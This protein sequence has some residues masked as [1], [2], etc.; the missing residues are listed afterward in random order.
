VKT[1]ATSSSAVAAA[2]TNWRS[3]S[4]QNLRSQSE[5]FGNYQRGGR[6]S[7]HNSRHQQNSNSEAFQRRPNS[8]NYYGSRQ[9]NTAPSAPF[10][11]LLL[12][13]QNEEANKVIFSYYFCVK[14]I[15][16]YLFGSKIVAMIYL[17]E[18]ITSSKILTD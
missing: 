18:N 11:E 10:S 5:F 7:Y 9:S 14:F 8:N 13:V 2:G 17:E 4:G 16:T 12:E 6:G 1:S 15:I 3:T